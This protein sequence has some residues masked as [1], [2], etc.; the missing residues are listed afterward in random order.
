[1][2]RARRAR[3]RPRGNR[4][5]AAGTSARR[6][7]PRAGAGGT[8]AGVIVTRSRNVSS[9]M[10]RRSGTSAM[11]SRSR[12]A[13][14]RSQAVSVT[15]ATRP[16]G[17]ARPPPAA[18]RCARMSSAFVSSTRPNRRATSTTSSGRFTWTWRRTRVALP[19]TASESPRGDAARRRA[20]RSIP[21]PDRRTSVHQRKRSVSLASRMRA[22]TRSSGTGR[23]GAPRTAYPAATPWRKSTKPCPP[24]S[25][26]PA[27]RRTVSWSGVRASAAPAAGSAAANAD[28]QSPLRAETRPVSSAQASRT[29]RRVPSFGWAIAPRAAL[30]AARARSANAGAGRRAALSTPSANPSS[31]C[32]KIAPELPRA[33]RRASSAARRAT[34]ARLRSRV[35]ATAAETRSSVA[36]RF[37]PVSRSATGKTLMRSIASR[38]KETARAPATR[39]RAKRRP[40]RNGMRTRGI[41]GILASE[42]YRESAK[43]FF[44]LESGELLRAASQETSPEGRPPRARFARRVAVED[45]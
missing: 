27:L 36:A 31:A 1:M 6:C 45:P 40:S 12:S 10:R 17:R 28:A 11:P 22:S 32:A 34:A 37:E 8:L 35:P 19:T 30:A 38:R 26:T 44:C 39:A 33:P 2:S 42:K 14:G 29:E 43:R 23:A 15:I 18:S 24:A 16:G 13:S 25:T 9:P 20:S 3:R 4:P 21:A 7:P 5:A 41:E